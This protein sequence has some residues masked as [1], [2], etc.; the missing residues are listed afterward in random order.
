M[1]KSLALMLSALL[2]A[3]P[4]VYAQ[5]PSAEQ[6]AIVQASSQDEA[7]IRALLNAYAAA[8]KSGETQAVLAL[9]ADNG[10][11]MAPAAPTADNPAALQAA[12]AQ[13]FAAVGL[14]LRF[15]VAEIVVSGQYAFVRSTS[16]GT[17]YV[18]AQKASVPEQ[19]RELFV[20]EKIHGEWKILR[21][22][23]NK[24]S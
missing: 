15:Q 13:I 23:F 20:L 10:V 19:N 9:Y 7:A 1:K 17:A 21:Y 6:T 24:T 3:V 18:K 5:T 16:D 22:M 11:L 4:T 2:L 8:L 14:D 12:Y